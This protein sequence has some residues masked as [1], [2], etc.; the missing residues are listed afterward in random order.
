MKRTNS[1]IFSGPAA[2]FP[3]YL[4]TRLCHIMFTMRSWLLS[5]PMDHWLTAF[6]QGMWGMEDIPHLVGFYHQ[7]QPGDL[8]Y[9]YA[10]SPDQALIGVG[11]ATAKRLSKRPLWKEEHAQGKSIYPHR[12]LFE[13][14]I[15]LGNNHCLPEIKIEFRTMTNG[16]INPLKPEKDRIL[17]ERVHDVWNL[18]LPTSNNKSSIKVSLRSLRKWFFIPNETIGKFTQTRLGAFFAIAGWVIAAVAGIIAIIRAF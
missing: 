4:A 17:R 7:V 5:G 12:L 3:N 10:T 1:I 16:A 15:F 6:E 13:S 2:F 9:F 14:L 8:F 18:H 11:I